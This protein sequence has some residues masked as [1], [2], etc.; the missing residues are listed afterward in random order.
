MEA[1]PPT[2]RFSQVQVLES[3]RFPSAS[4]ADPG[5]WDRRLLVVMKFFSGYP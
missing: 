1:F 4:T 5:P 2:N 3:A